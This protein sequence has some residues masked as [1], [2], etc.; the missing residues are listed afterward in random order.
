MK[1]VLFQLGPF[2]ISSFGLFLLLA[3]LIGISMVR[4]RAATLGIDPAEMLDVGLYM[5]I[6]GIVGGRL[7]FVVTNLK[8]FAQ[9]P[10]SVI[11]I[12][13]DSGL[14]FY[15]A[16]VGGLVVAFVYATRRRISLGALLDLIAPALAVGYAVA[17]IGALLH[18]LFNGKPTGLPWA[19]DM[20]FEKRHPTQLYL[21]VAALGIY[22]VLRSLAARPHAP[23]Y[24]FITFLFLH[25][26]ARGVVEIFVETQP[27][28]GSVTAM[29]L[30]CAVVALV[31]LTGM[32]ILGKRRPAAG[33]GPAMG[34]GAPGA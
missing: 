13:R 2:P 3:F 19:V 17:M 21:L 23:G 4:R 28:F 33:T 16:V 30:V 20:F 18:G 25:A 14:T 29:Q 31:A 9:N 12:W 10:G 26:V 22:L 15:G 1:P 27:V 5:I 34:D 7:G 11:T 24:L 6:G 8:T 32:S